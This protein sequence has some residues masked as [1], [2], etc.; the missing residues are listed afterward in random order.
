MNKIIRILHLEDDVADMELVQATLESAGIV[1]QIN[2]VQ[3]REEFSE[4]VSKGGYDVILADYGLPM[5]DGMSALQLI[6]ELQLDVPFIF[7]SGT[8]GEDAAIEGL[9]EGATDYVLKQKLSRLAPALKRALLEAENKRERKQ[10][11]EELRKLN[12]ELKAVSNCNQTL[13]RA[14]DE[15]S[16]LNDICRII[17]DEAGYR[18]AWVGYADEH[19]DAKTVRPVAWG[20]FDGEYVA[21]AKVSWADD[22]ERAQ[23]PGG[24]AIRSGKTVYM[25]DFTT[26]PR[27]APWRES[28]LQRGYRSTIA[29]PLKDENENIFGVLLIYSTEINSFTPDEIR[30]LEELAGDLA[31]GIGVLRIRDER[32]Q[33]EEGLKNAKELSESIIRNSP[34]GIL[35][36][37]MDGTIAGVNSAALKILGSPSEEKTK[38]F[39]VLTMENMVNQGISEF[40]ACCLKKGETIIDE[41]LEYISIWGKRLYISLSIVPLMTSDNKQIGAIAMLNDIT[42]RKLAEDSLKESEKKYRLLTENASDVIWILNTKKSKFTYISPSVFYLLGVTAEEA[43]NGTLEDALTPES[44]AVMSEVIARN[45]AFFAEHPES[46]RSYI[47]QV[48]EPCKNGDIIWVD[49]STKYRYNNEGDIEIVGVSRNIDERKKSEKEIL[50]LGYHDPLTG[51]YNRRLYEEELNRLDTERNLP[52]TLVMGDV[53]G[54]KLINDSFGHAMG[55]RLLVKVAEVLRK[56]C[57]TDDIIARL[58]GDEFVAILPKTDTSEAEGIITRIKDQLL[59][60][61]IGF[62]GIS[63]SVGY[64]T[65]HKM[66]ESI[67]EI[68]KKTEDHMYRH[69]LFESSSMRSKT[70]DLIMNTLFEKNER[71]MLHS[72]RVSGICEAIANRMDLNKD[73][74]NQIR[75]AGLMHDIG[76][77]G[78]DDKILNTPQALDDDEWKEIRKHPEVGYRI[79]HSV[80]E[81]SEIA[82][83]ILAHHERW[84][85][86]G[87]PRGLIGEEIPLRARIIAVADAF[88]AMTIGRPY[89][90]ALNKEEAI[91]EIQRCSGTQFDP[92]I[93]KV[94]IA[95]ILKSELACD[96]GN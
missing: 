71:E 40:F 74:V 4:A 60:E 47:N 67:Q 33:M 52:L 62:I 36:T 92:E 35:S 39:N 46:T 55:D 81:F 15:Q 12:R 16:L 85:G 72:K 38:Q 8:M 56:G 69:K 82:G 42:G 5:Y 14:E 88:D 25:Q 11:E 22:A 19:D 9:T 75:V 17:C 10:A 57:R 91:N 13:L 94:F 50:Y 73:D 58:G 23:G 90:K 86:E 34:V 65:K 77:I 41:N 80:T 64:G 76:K 18:L 96:N 32:K 59:E 51:L 70:I 79:L 24:A 68:I 6:K 83:D 89:K 37:G 2:R 87:Y 29:L 30:L 48:Q 27:M 84:D 21:N 7:V 78:I 31:F 20:G 45:V 3:T 53:N 66:E 63:I 1:Y 93:V 95:M 26:D 43:M 61:K 44:F 28:A 54:L 49:I